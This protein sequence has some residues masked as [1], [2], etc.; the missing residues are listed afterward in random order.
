MDCELATRI[1]SQAYRKGALTAVADH[2]QLDEEEGV[3]LGRHG[4]A[5]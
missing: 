5:S 4:W 3:L 2:K 1:S